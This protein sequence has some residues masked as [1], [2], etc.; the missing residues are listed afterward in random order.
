MCGRFTH[1]F[2]WKEIRDFLDLHWPANP[3]QLDIS[4]NVAPTQMSPVVR[5]DREGQRGLVVSRWGLVPFW[6]DDP[7]IGNRLIN[8]RADGI[9][10][11]P[12]FRSAFKR[13]RCVVPVSGFY[14]WQPIAGSKTK[15]P[16]YL[17]RA[18]GAVTL[19]AGLWERWTKDEQK[20]PLETFTIITTDANEMMKPIHNRM[21]V[22]L[23]RDQVDQWLDD[24]T[25]PEAL[26]AMLK[27][28]A[29]DTLRAHPV[30]LR[31]NTPRNN[32]PSLIEPLDVP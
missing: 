24:R 11:K 12:A 21:P 6:S 26:E 23:E 27:P 29:D 30:S 22:I 4:F 5:L 14:E 16:W 9:A 28:A 17:T 1:N 7:S 19:F 15:C 18:D 10:S 8:A 25:S 2:T 13:H 31:V 3:E 20:G 32:D